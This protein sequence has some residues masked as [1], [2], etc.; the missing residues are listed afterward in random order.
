MHDIMYKYWK[1][2]FSIY[3]FVS[4]SCLASRPRKI[5][6]ANLHI[7]RKLFFPLFKFSWSTK[8]KFLTLYVLL[9]V[10]LLQLEEK[11]YS[12]TLTNDLCDKSKNKVHYGNEKK[13]HKTTSK[14]YLLCSFVLRAYM[15]FTI[16]FIHYSTIANGVKKFFISSLLW[17]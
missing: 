6:N 17:L 7:C 8:C 16:N 9:L 13:V 3:I 15:S 4:L 11:L 14:E 12:S 2:P 5:F 10:L 1:R